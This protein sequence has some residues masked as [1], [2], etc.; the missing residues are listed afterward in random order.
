ME[1]LLI[2]LFNQCL[3]YIK[4][5]PINMLVS[6]SKIDRHNSHL[7]HPGEKANKKLCHSDGASVWHQMTNGVTVAKYRGG[8]LKNAW[9]EKWGSGYN[10][11]R[12]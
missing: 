5:V 2:Y 4:H 12:K 1:Y 8:S 10:S 9:W 7:Y 3:L 11:N 6:G